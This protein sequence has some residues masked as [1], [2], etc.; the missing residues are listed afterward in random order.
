MSSKI[1]YIF[2]Q[3]FQNTFTPGYL[4]SSS[5]NITQSTTKEGNDI[6]SINDSNLNNRSSTEKGLGEYFDISFNNPFDVSNLESIIIYSAPEIKNYLIQ[7][8]RYETTGNVK[9]DVSE[10][11]LWVDNKNIVLQTK[12]PST[13]V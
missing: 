6:N 4:D 3:G 1:N 13:F 8:V 12:T 2:N 7:K 9:L 10:I 11:Q 5:V